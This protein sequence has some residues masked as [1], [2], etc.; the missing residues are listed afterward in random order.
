MTGILVCVAGPSG[1]GKDSLIRY[2]SDRLSGN[3]RYRFVRRIITR[4]SHAELEDHDEIAM[5]DFQQREAQGGFFLT[6]KAHGLSYALPFNIHSDISSGVT[7]IANLSRSSLAA[8]VIRS[9]RAIILAVT[10]APHIL[11]ARLLARG[12]EDAQS[13]AM[14]LNRVVPP[15]PPEIER[16]E[17]DNSGKLEEAGETMLAI[18]KS[19]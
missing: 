16:V 17:I 1:A 14:R 19:L 15:W 11:E 2:C 18:L 3:P 6:W 4:T 10:A 8:P 12:R 13:A 7:V 9:R 5:A